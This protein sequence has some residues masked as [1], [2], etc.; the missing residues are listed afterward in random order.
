MKTVFIFALILIWSSV[1]SG[2]STDRAVSLP[3]SDAVHSEASGGNETIRKLTEIPETVPAD[4]PNKMMPSLLKETKPKLNSSLTVGRMIWSIFIA[5]MAF[6]FIKYTIRLLETIA[7]KWVNLRLSIMRMIPFIRIL[8]WTAVIYFIIAAIL[9]P[10]IETLLA[11]TASAGIALGFSS[12]DILKNIFGGLMILVDHPFQIGDKIQIREHY[13]EVI[14]IGLR[15]VR[16]VT[17]DD[18][19][20]SIPNGDIVSQPVSNANNGESNC[21]VVAEFFLPVGIDLAQLKKIAFRAAV[22]SRFVYLNKPIAIVFKNEIHEGL[23]I[24]KMRVKAYV[25]DI[26]YE[27]AFASDITELVTEALI[28]CNLISQDRSPLYSNILRPV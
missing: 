24:L 1:V 8:V 20:I 13:G 11:L 5:L 10:P 3:T 18:S 9:S 15:T 19:I 14:Q 16:I 21:Q 25:L 17:P 7:E 28:R 12:Q 2:K 22:V 23:S 26:R 6:F 4:S 27:F